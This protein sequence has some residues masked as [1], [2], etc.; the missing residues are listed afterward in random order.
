M[1]I[2]LFNMEM[3][4]ILSRAS[5][6]SHCFH[7]H[8]VWV[9]LSLFFRA[10]MKLSC[11][12]FSCEMCCLFLEKEI[13]AQSLFVFRRQYSRNPSFLLR[14]CL[15]HWLSEIYCM[16]IIYESVMICFGLIFY[17]ILRNVKLYYTIITDL[18]MI[19]HWVK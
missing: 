5:C 1:K 4:S 11:L 10:F 7:C 13:W 16:N 17:T 15:L 14:F 9:S 8:V 19:I 3:F 18:E 12:F 6:L 2:N